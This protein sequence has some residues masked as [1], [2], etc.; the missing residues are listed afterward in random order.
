MS[1][2]REPLGHPEIYWLRVRHLFMGSWSLKLQKHYFRFEK[3]QFNV[4][5]V[6]L[7]DYIFKY[8]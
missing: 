8:L 2:L 3:F 4:S 5:F 6:H 7:H 1:I